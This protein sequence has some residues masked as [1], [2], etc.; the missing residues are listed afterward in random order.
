MIQFVDKIRYYDFQIYYHLYRLT[1]AHHYAY[2]I[3]YFFA[4]YGIVLFFLSFIYLV[5]KR[6][7]PAFLCTLLAMGV[8]GL[9]DLLVFMFWQRPRPFITYDALVHPNITGM[10]ADISSFPSSHTYIVFAI[11]TSVFLYG[12]RKLGSFLFL[13]AIGVAVGRIAVGLHYPSDVIGGG[14]LGIA[15]GVLVYF[16]F[17]QWERAKEHQLAKRSE[18]KRTLQPEAPVS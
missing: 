8:A 1:T 3:A 11:A 15:S 13:L 17:N 16:L 14:I 2:N 18:Q 5:I 7:I 12:H 4:R 10:Y 6:K 9:V